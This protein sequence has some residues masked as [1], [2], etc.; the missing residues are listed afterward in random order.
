[1]A[2]SSRHY[3][4]VWICV[5]DQIFIS[6]SLFLHWFFFSF[7]AL[8]LTAELLGDTHGHMAPKVRQSLKYPTSKLQTV[9]ILIFVGIFFEVN[10][11]A[12]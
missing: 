5:S 12:I 6:C 2:N 7:I 8:G 11:Y 1:M 3:Q 4:T 9:W 10:R